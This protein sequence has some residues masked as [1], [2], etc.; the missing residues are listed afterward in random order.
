MT[1]T[2]T[3]AEQVAEIFHND[4]MTWTV[5]INGEDLDLVDAMRQYGGELDEIGP[6]REERWLFADGSVITLAEEAW[7][8]GYTG[9]F[10][11]SGIGHNAGCNSEE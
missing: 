6:D 1:T 4:G 11:W 2:K 9:C 10:C 7:D 8:L 5:E 3:T